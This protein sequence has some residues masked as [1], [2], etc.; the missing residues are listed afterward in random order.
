MTGGLFFHT[1]EAVPKCGSFKVRFP[2]IRD[3]AGAMMATLGLP[4]WLMIVGAL[5]VVVGSIGVLVSGKKA[6][7][8]DSLFD[9][10]TDTPRQQVPPLPRLLDSKR[11]NNT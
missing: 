1:P 2:G 8:V 6:D 10:P 9:D 5:L 3:K 4:H 11:K 7:E